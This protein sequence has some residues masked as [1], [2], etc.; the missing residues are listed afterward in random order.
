M[1]FWKKLGSGLKKALPIAVALTPT[2]IDDIAFG[3]VK[4]VLDSPPADQQNMLRILISESI[5]KVNPGLSEVALARTT[6][7]VMAL[8]QR[9]VE[10]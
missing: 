4:Q 9:K 8:I 7:E 3:L 2:P 5:R 6:A 1:G 10:P